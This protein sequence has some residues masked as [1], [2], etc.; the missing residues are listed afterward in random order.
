MKG[1]TYEELMWRETRGIGGYYPEIGKL[2]HETGIPLG[3]DFAVGELGGF[4]TYASGNY[5]SLESSL[6]Y[7]GVLWQHDG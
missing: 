3:L 1:P 6:C 5:Q 7:E 4:G 2:L